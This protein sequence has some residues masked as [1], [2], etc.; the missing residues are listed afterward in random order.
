[1]KNLNLQKNILRVFRDENYLN[2]AIIDILE[3]LILI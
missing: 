2:K 3:E 1:M